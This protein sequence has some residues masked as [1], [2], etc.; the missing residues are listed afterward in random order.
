MSTATQC[1]RCLFFRGLCNFSC[2]AGAVDA[3][4]DAPFDVQASAA[5]GYKKTSGA[6]WRMAKRLKAAWSASIASVLLA[7]GQGRPS[8]PPPP[9]A[10]THTSPQIPVPSISLPSPSLSSPAL[11]P[12]PI[13]PLSSTSLPLP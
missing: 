9:K 7:D 4:H 11:P 13:L 8:P 1:I 5:N 2:E 12:H 3:I 10:M 6:A